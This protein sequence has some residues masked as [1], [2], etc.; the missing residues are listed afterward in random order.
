MGKIKVDENG[1]TTVSGVYAAGDAIRIMQ[2]VILAASDGAIAE[3]TINHDL[4]N[5]DTTM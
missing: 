3:I 1:R 2:Q 4:V 5:E